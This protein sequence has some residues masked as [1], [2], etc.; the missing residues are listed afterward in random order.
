[1]PTKEQMEFLIGARNKRDAERHP[2]KIQAGPQENTL[3]KGDQTV[4]RDEPTFLNLDPQKIVQGAE[5]SEKVDKFRKDL[6]PEAIFADHL[7]SLSR[8]NAGIADNTRPVMDSEIARLDKRAPFDIELVNKEQAVKGIGT[9]GDTLTKR[10]SVEDNFKTTMSRLDNE[11]RAINQDIKITDRE[12]HN[13]RVFSIIDTAIKSLGS[14]LDERQN[15]IIKQTIFNIVEKSG[16]T[17]YSALELERMVD[18]SFA[19]NR[20]FRK[21]K[22]KLDRKK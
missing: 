8:A 10:Q 6:T 19:K 21:R 3:V 9:L 15:A 4:E 16:E 22:K 1:M 11:L 7:S 18:K 2:A 17:D 12:S 14:G 13:K 5:I 20:L